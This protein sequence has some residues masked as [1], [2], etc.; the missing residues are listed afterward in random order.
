MTSQLKRSC[1]STDAVLRL[2]EVSNETRLP[3]ETLHVAQLAQ[4][5]RDS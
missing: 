4:E 5:A 3:W 2:D 1:E